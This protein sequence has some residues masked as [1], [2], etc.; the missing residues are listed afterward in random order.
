MVAAET[1]GVVREQELPVSGTAYQGHPPPRLFSP[2]L[3]DHLRDVILQHGEQHA[4]QGGHPAEAPVPVHRLLPVHGQGPHTG[5]GVE[6]AGNQPLVPQ[7]AVLL[8]RPVEA[9][10][11]PCQQTS[12]VGQLGELNLLDS[13]N[14][15]DSKSDALVL[16]EQTGIFRRKAFIERTGWGRTLGGAL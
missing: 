12:D 7:L 2:E 9:L 15:L 1:R 14:H 11:L 16:E 3:P 10:F 13:G 4:V 5:P 6:E 8:G